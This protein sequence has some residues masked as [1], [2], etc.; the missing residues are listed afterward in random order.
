MLGRIVKYSLLFIGVAFVLGAGFVIREVGSKSTRI[1]TRW[2]CPCVYVE[3]RDLEYCLSM[4][5]VP[6]GSIVSVKADD[7]TQSVEASSFFF[8]KSKA[9]RVPKQSCVMEY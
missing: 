2:A 8:F 7:A 6:V 9:R 1:A 5:P 3:G 4:T